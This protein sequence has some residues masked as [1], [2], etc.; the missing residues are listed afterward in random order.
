MMGWRK[1]SGSLKELAVKG[2]SEGSRTRSRTSE[3]QL[4]EGVLDKIRESTLRWFGYVQRR[5]C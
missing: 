3:E 5:H 1:V 2:G 4:M